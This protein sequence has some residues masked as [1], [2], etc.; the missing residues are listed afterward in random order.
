M[1]VPFQPAVDWLNTDVGT[2]AACYLGSLALLTAWESVA[3]PRLKL[4]GIL[5]DVPILPGQLTE[6]EL[7][8]PWILPITADQSIPLPDIDSLRDKE[9]HHVGKIEKVSQVISIPSER[10]SIIK[11]KREVSEEWSSYYGTLICI[12]KRK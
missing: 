11:G 1:L 10:T 9:R 8:L 4:N 3:V 12:E 5:P 7:R 6:R 2:G